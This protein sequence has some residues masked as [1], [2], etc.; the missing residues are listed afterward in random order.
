MNHRKAVAL[1]YDPTDK[2]PRILAHGKN[3]Q[4]DRILELAQ[5]CGIKIVNNP[6]LADILTEAEIGLY[7]PEETYEAVAAIFAFLEKGIHD[8]WF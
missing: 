4:A 2:A 6:I 3:I 8:E 7:I 1:G 5:T